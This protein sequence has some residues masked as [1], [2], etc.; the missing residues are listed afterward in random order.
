VPEAEESRLRRKG[1]KGE[2]K[3]QRCQSADHS[4]FLSAVWLYRCRCKGVNFCPVRCRPRTACLVFRT[5]PKCSEICLWCPVLSNA[6]R[7]GAEQ[8][9]FGK[10][11]QV[12]KFVQIGCVELRF[13][14][15]C[16]TRRG[17]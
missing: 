5:V 16:L 15:R 1:D 14:T 11:V 7:M 6:P 8:H 17:W 9:G 4:T 10:C 2:Q 13:T 3:E 12:S